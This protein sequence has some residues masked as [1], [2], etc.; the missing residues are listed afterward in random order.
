MRSSSPSRQALTIFPIRNRALRG[1]LAT[2]EPGAVRGRGGSIGQA[3]YRLRRAALF[4]L[5]VGLALAVACSSVPQPDESAAATESSVFEA[6]R[7]LLVVAHQDDDVFIV[8][9]IK[10]HL[11]A[12]AEVWVVWTASSEPFGEEYAE[13][14]VEEARQAAGLL[15]IPRS[16]LYFLRYPDG[17]THRALLEIITELRAVIAGV[18]PDIVYVPAYEMGHIDHDIAHFAAVRTTRDLDLDCRLV[19]FPIYSAFQTGWPFPFRLRRYPKS[20]ETQV[21]AL[22]E[23]EYGFVVQ[24]WG[25]YAS[26]KSRFG[27]Y[28]SFISSKRSVLGAEFTRDVPA[29]DYEAPPFD[30]RAAY[31][32]FLNDVTFGDFVAAVGRLKSGDDS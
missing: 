22:A 17:A 13:R 21:R 15:G 3:R 10:R 31:E 25:V 6:K 8:S 1:T 9:R 24:Y 2:T 30:A 27:L 26:Q 28:M 7:V 4:V 19:E 5:V 12:G 20:L 18:G 32:K 29:Y 11:E 14:R 23:D 16:N